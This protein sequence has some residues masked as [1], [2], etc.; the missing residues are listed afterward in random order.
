MTGRKIKLSIMP[1]QL[2][3]TGFYLDTF[4][5]IAHEMHEKTRKAFFSVFRVF[6]GP[7]GNLTK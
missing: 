7:K 4:E 3:I 1:G 2:W 6:S 5:L